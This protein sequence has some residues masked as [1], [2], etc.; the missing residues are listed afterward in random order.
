[1]DKQITPV[2]QPPTRQHQQLKQ[3]IATQLAA[4]TTELLYQQPFLAMLL[5]RLSIRVVVD[6]RLQT[7]ATD[8]TYIYADARF[9]APLTQQDRLFVLAHEVW[10]CAMGHFAR[11]DFLSQ[12]A[13]DPQQWNIA[14][15]YEV[16][17][18]VRSQL[19]YLAPFALYQEAF[20]GM[21]AEQIF[22]KLNKQSSPLQAAPNQSQFDCHHPKVSA[23]DEADGN[24]N[25]NQCP[26]I[27]DRDYQPQAAKPA[28]ANRWRQYVAQAAQVARSRG[29]DIG[30]AAE[31]ALER[32]LRPKLPWTSILR[33]YIEQSFGGGQTWQPISR[34][35]AYQGLILPGQCTPKLS[36]AVAIDTSGSTHNDLTRFFSELHGILKSFQQVEVQVIECDLQ[37][38]Q[39]ASFSEQNIDQLKNWRP[40]GG[41][42]TSF[43]PVFEYLANQRNGLS[44]PNLLVFFTDG[45]G[46]APLQSPDYPVLWVL[47]VDGRRP[48]TPD[49]H[50]AQGI[51]WGQFVSLDGGQA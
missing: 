8:G 7:A 9:F 48:S 20:T 1:M 11:R 29:T 43:V 25:G 2:S 32:L 18:I 36:I 39:H 21:S 37:V 35:H 12:K 34:R 30:H 15:D 42:G 46:D 31:L 26:V 24:N 16:N 40:R 13:R 4:D 6:D 17:H 14:C 19:N 44:K 49:Y 27:I 51:Q 45:Y 50:D 33:R 41:G 5:M 3:R 10:H 47:T 23:V 38:Q 28:D 22:V